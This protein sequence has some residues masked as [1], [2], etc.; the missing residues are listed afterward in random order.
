MVQPG[1]S[2]MMFRRFSAAPCTIFLTAL[3]HAAVAELRAFLVGVSDYLTLDVDLKGPADDVRLMAEVLV[4]RGIP[5]QEIAVLTSDPSDR[6]AGV[7]TASPTKAE[8][9]SALTNMANRAQPGDTVIFYFSGHGAQAPDASGDEGGGY[10]EIFRPADAAGSKG[11]VGSVE[12]ALSD[13]ELQAW[14][15][16]LLAGGGKLVGLIDACHSDTGFRSLPNS[17]GV[18]RGL[19]RKI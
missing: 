4:A 18:A 16:P 12:N 3:P 19:S 11:D 14:A 2:A 17:A 5:A 13:D 1:Y 9:L 7:T 15:Q 8:I 6:P 10:D